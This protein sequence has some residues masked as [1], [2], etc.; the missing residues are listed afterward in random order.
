MQ[1]VDGYHLYQVGQAL[2]KI[3]DLKF[4]W[5]DT[6]TRGATFQ[7]ALLVL[8]DAKEMLGKLLADETYRLKTCIQK[9]NELTEAIDR[10]LN[11]I[12]NTSEKD[13]LLSFSDIWPIKT[14]I[15]SFQAVLSSELNLIDLYIITKKGG[16]DTSILLTDGQDCFPEALESKVPECMQDIRDGTKCL[17][18]S[19]PTAAGFHLLRAAEAVMRKYWDV[20]TDQQKRPKTGN[21]GDYIKKLEE[22]EVGHPKVL[23]ALKNLKDLHRNELFH[24]GQHIENLEEAIAL[25]NQI[26]T[27]IFYMLKDIPDLDINQK[28]KSTGSL[29]PPQRITEAPKQKAA[30]SEHDTKQTGS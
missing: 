11:K 14:A 7:E 18:V 2:Q 6:E 26:H 21:M 12:D 13:Q 9:G 27:I 25:M 8:R 23:S 4:N 10:L 28:D 16:F 15:Q 29:L 22:L 1:K 24:P 5:S 3:E 30:N 20:V 17:A 19:L